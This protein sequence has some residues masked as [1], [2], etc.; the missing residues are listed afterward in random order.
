MISLFSLKIL[1]LAGTGTE[2][3]FMEVLYNQHT[4]DMFKYQ[5]EKL[6]IIMKPKTITGEHVR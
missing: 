3:K 4:T 6:T 1:L 2:Q 5:K